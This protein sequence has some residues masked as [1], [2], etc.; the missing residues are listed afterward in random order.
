MSENF[1]ASFM[2]ALAS[3]E[4]THGNK[5]SGEELESLKAAHVKKFWRGMA[6][7][8][9]S[10]DMDQLSE[11]EQDELIEK[12]KRKNDET[13]MAKE[14]EAKRVMHGMNADRQDSAYRYFLS[15]V[16]PRYIDAQLS[17]FSSSSTVASHIL[18]GGSCL[19]LGP[20]GAGKTRLMYAVAKSLAR[21][22]E[23]GEVVVSSLTMLLAG[24]TAN[25]GQSWQQYASEHY[26][27]N[28][29]LLMLDEVDK[30][31]ASS[32]DYE[33]TNLIIGERYDNKL[34][35]VMVGNGTIENI[36]G[37]LGDAVISRMVGEKDGGKLFQLSMSI[38][39]RRQ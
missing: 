12:A 14:L 1:T 33:I 9:F 5:A 10:V 2:S 18:N 23:Y 28:T 30:I 19:I 34:Q 4:K 31:K 35:T 37:I 24:I 16:P 21:N 8:L 32:F 6:S 26:G 22:Y 25:G 17:D 27:K 15:T 20:V 11:E 3:F 36:R 29:K 38:K 7:R 39:D 13:V